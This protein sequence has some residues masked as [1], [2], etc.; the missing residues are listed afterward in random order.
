MKKLII[1]LFGASLVVSACDNM[2]EVD[3]TRSNRFNMAGMDVFTAESENP[4]GHTK[5]VLNQDG[6]IDWQPGDSIHI[7]KGK[8]DCG[9]F[10]ATIEEQAITSDFIGQLDYSEEDKDGAYWAIYPYSKDNTCDGKSVTVH[11][12]DKQVAT[13]GT[14]D[15]KAFVSIAHSD[16]QTLS[17]YNVCGG[18]KISVT[19]PN[20]KRIIFK[21][22]AGET[23]AGDAIV[24]MDEN[25][26]PVVQSITNPKTEVTVEAP[27]DKVF[28]VGKWYYISCLPNSLAKGCSVLF[29]MENDS[30]SADAD[31]SINKPIVIKRSIWGRIQDSDDEAI[32][33]IQPDDGLIVYTT[34]D[35]K[36]VKIDSSLF[37]SHIYKNGLGIIKLKDGTVTLMIEWFRKNESLK[38]VG[39]GKGITSISEGAFYG[40]S[41]LTS[42]TIPEG[43]TSFGID[44][45]S[46]CS[47]LTSITIPGSVTSIGSSAFSGC[48]SL[49]SFNSPYASEDKRCLVVD[50]WLAGFCPAGLESYTIPSSVTIINN[51]TFDSYTGSIS[52]TIPESVT[53]IG[54]YAFSRYTGLKSVT[55]PNSISKINN[56][57]FY[58]CTGLK[59][60]TIPSS[61]TSIGESAFTG[62]KSLTSITIPEGVKSIGRYAF[63]S[64]KSLTEMIVL[65]STP[66]SLSFNA[67]ESTN[68]AA[69][70]VPAESVNAYKSASA[71]SRW[72]DII[73]AILPE[74]IDLGLSVKWASCNL[75]A[76]KP[77]E[78]GGYYAW[79]EIDPKTSYS[80]VNYKFRISGDNIDNVVLAKYNTKDS[81]GNVDNIGVLESGDDAASVKLGGKWR[82]PTDAEWTELRTKCTWTWTDNYNGTGVK[83]RIVTASNGNCIFLPAAGNRN[84]TDLLDAGSY[85]FY[86]SSSL[87]TDDPSGALNV[88]FNSGNVYSNG[89]TRCIG[90][91]LRPVC[92]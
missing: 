15:K 29:R 46:G 23:L 10:V 5:T 13:E 66:P 62:C 65:R 45:F 91:S 47:S 12:P 76:I 28:E 85:G 67:L 56:G 16:K 71:W 8:S 82:I 3:D 18:V 50:G 41:S 84:G 49:L 69:I 11:I 34:T 25:G 53:T 7:F 37:V 4:S 44:A 14:F 88:Q 83:G 21:G 31:Y 68:I 79:G 80:W 52:I 74:A 24:T 61:V 48:N 17:F 1:F 92:D 72:R 30:F 42:I 51:P 78:Y 36:A 73:K 89:L 39:I 77:E 90:R 32:Y 58:G 81:Y 75:G 19:T 54:N 35:N 40:C 33:T 27:A 70:Y 22:N 60:V 2:V 64:C 55:I 57:V 86:W 6:G 59:Q 38:Y 43:V 20:I 26:R 9:A 87:S 63:Q